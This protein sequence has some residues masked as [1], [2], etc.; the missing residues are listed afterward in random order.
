VPRGLVAPGVA[1]FVTHHL[2]APL[3]GQLWHP[4]L[5]CPLSRWLRGR[6]RR[7]L[8]LR[9]ERFGVAATQG[10]VRQRLCLTRGAR[11]G[12]SLA[13][14]ATAVAV[15]SSL[16]ASSVAQERRRLR[17]RSLRLR[18]HLQPRL[19]LTSVATATLAVASAVLATALAL[20]NVGKTCGEGQHSRN[21]PRN[22]QRNRGVAIGW[23][24]G[25][26]RKGGAY[27]PTR[28]P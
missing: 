12:L 11:R 22:R 9:I 8:D 14:R 18:G 3:L 19:R 5:A 24:K 10:A 21:R 28:R 15:A 4:S 6:A 27:R 25:G 17:F 13:R 7:R 20:S 23:P 2:A 26:V 16:A 1:P